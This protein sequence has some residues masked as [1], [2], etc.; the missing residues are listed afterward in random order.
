MK[1]FDNIKKSLTEENEENAEKKKLW[2]TISSLV[3]EAQDA[4][5]DAASAAIDKVG[6]LKQTISSKMTDSYEMAC[7]FAVL[8]IKKAVKQ[9]DLDELLE[10]IDEVQKERNLNVGAL[11]NFIVELKEFSEDGNK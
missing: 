8:Q 3:D 9:I 10:K 1:L 4:I 5:S 11:R 2:E 7:D 6:D